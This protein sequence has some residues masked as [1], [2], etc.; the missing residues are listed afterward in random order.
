MTTFKFLKQPLLSGLYEPEGI[1]LHAPLDGRYPIVLFWGAHPEFYGQFTYNGIPLKGHIGVD[2]AA[3]IGAKLLA[4]APGRVTEIS[5]EAHGFG[6]Y[7]KIEHAWGESLYAHLEELVV[8]SGQIVDRGQHLGESGDN[9][10]LLEPHLHFGLRIKPYNRFDGWGGFT[11]PVPFFSETDIDLR[12]DEHVDT[13][14]QPWRPAPMA[15]ETNNFRR[16]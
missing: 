14:T 10:G 3:P 4:V 13:D 15:S 8:E 16:P 7:L 11:D 6:R 9:N 1:Y 12:D 2:F 5:F